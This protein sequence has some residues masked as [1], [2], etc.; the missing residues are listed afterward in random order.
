MKN[1]RIGCG[2]GFQ[3][4]RIKPAVELAQNGDIQYLVFECLAERTIGLAQKER[5][6][7]PSGGYDI[8][9]EERM[10]AVLPTCKKNGIKII[11]NMGAANPIGGMKKI[12]ET[13]R[14][15]DL[16][17]LKIAAVTGDDVFQEVI[18]G[19]YIVSETGLPV[20]A[21]N[22]PVSANA[23]IGA[24]GLVEALKEGADIVIAGRVADAALFLAPLIYEF[25][26]S[27]D[28]YDILSKGTM[29]GHLLEC[30]G[31]VTG[32]YFADPGYKDVPDLARLGYPLAE[33]CEDGTA[34]ITKTSGSGGLVSIDTCKEQLL[35][36]IQDPT[37]YITPDVVA[38][39]SGAVLTEIGKDRVK[40]QGAKGKKRPE[41]LKVS[42]VYHDSFVGEGELSYAGSGAV[43]RGKLALEVVQERLKLSGV[44]LTETRFDL[45]GVNAL[46]AKLS[47]V[48][49]NA[50]EVR[51]RA[52]GRA[53]NRKDAFSVC[54][55]IAGLGLG[56]PA[57]GGGGTGG[58]TEVFGVVSTFIPRDRVNLSIQYEVI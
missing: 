52:V 15:L 29:I 19:D 25:S 39:F 20:Q 38:D 24:G 13:A 53:D 5:S 21:L 57:G 16:S 28:D 41:L 46:H 49:E 42:V 36:E 37:S 10:K 33:V 56:G 12:A 7:N 34:I 14:E 8:L 58:V 18:K 17:G 2:A 11:T 51:I 30:C 55:E 40:V 48:H 50:Y 47:C 22:Q 9:L 35:Y 6:R 1:I 27:F 31:Q 43:E 32:G 23:Y 26:W 4:D 45:I 54:A 3:A 44:P